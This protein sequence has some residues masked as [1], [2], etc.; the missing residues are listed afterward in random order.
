MAGVFPTAGDPDLSSGVVAHL[1]RLREEM[2]HQVI[3]LQRMTNYKVGTTVS[4][5]IV[6]GGTARNTVPDACEAFIDVRAMTRDEM[7][8]LTA[9]I[10]AIE[11][12]LPGAR[13]EVEGGFDRPPMERNDLMIATF[14]RAKD[15]AGKHKLTIRE[16]GS[17][18]ASDGNYTAAL[19]AAGIHV[20]KAPSDMGGMI[21]KV[22]RGR[23]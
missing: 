4:V 21:E 15:I 6:S 20:V 17:G 10:L 16:A 5:G 3:A 11:P 19:S 23:A 22:W 7:D 12:V 13:L 9:Q 8:R 14:N 2:A 1:E 18:G